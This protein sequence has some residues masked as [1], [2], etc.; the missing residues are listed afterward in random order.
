M[1]SPNPEHATTS[2]GLC[3]WHVRRCGE[4]ALRTMMYWQC[5]DL[6]P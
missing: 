3:E 4:T 2:L 1:R 5:R 6:T